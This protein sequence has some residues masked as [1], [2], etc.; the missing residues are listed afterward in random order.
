M[1]L[2]RCV[3]FDNFLTDYQKVYLEQNYTVLLN[4]TDN[5]YLLCWN[6]S[7]LLQ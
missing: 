1:F 7:I 3:L 4:L 6:E 5:H 2:K